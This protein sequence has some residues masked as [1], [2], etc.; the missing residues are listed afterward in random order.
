MGLRERKMVDE[1]SE[2]GRMAKDDHDRPVRGKFCE[3]VLVEWREEGA[4]VDLEGTSRDGLIPRDDLARVGKD[5]EASL[6]PGDPVTVCVMQP[7][8]EEDFVLVSLHEALEEEDWRRA[9][10]LLESGDVW[11]GKPNSYNRGGLL[12]PFGRLKVFVPASHLGPENRQKRPFPRRNEFLA[13][14]VGR[15]LALQFIELSRERHRLVASERL[16]RER[17][18]EEA[19]ARL[20]SELREGDVCEGSVCHI[21]DFGVF[22]DLGGADGLIHISELSWGKV[23]HPR[24]VVK[25]GDHVEVYVLNVDPE[26]K[27]IGLSLKRMQPSPWAVAGERLVEGQLTGGVVTNVVDFG[28]FV[29]IDDLKVEGLLHIS[30]L[31]DPPPV[32]PRD[33]VKKGDRIVVRVLRIDPLRRRMRL[34]LRAVGDQERAE[35][36]AGQGR[37]RASG[38]REDP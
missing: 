10:S 30:E 4:V 18:R 14:F 36:F 28:A 15:K 8:T 34:S 32:H 26:Q 22:V 12:V 16:G 11:Y 2:A 33:E 29:A 13:G 25:V 5:Q 37:G 27:R 19:L 38:R 6:S 31:S 24:D 7:E 1:R 21:C 17:Q 3:G 9:E 35:W 23:R 20:L